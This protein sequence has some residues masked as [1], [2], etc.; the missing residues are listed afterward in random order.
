MRYA[1]AGTKSG[2]AYKTFLTMKEARAF[3]ENSADRK[4]SQGIDMQIV[5]ATDVW[6]K[7]CE[8]E[9]INGREPVSKYTLKN[10]TYRATF[11]KSYEWP[12]TIATLSAPDIVAFR[13]WLLTE[14]LS[15]E[16]ASK[17]LSSLHSLM[18]EMM[19]RGHLAHNPVSGISIRADS[20]YRRLSVSRT[21]GKLW[22]FLRPPI[23]SRPRRTS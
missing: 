12:K 20:R 1:A 19:V 10:Y 13:S 6:L 2:Y 17:V 15:R 11:I 7:A 21:N 16:V 18:K 3:R 9:G 4:H 14:G 23:A 5:Q 8:K 22:P